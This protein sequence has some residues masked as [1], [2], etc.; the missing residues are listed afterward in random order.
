MTNIRA[1]A[2]LAVLLFGS[3][4]LP[5]FAQS[6]RAR[7]P[8]KP[9]D[10]QSDTVRLRVEEVLLP[11]SVRTETGKLPVRVDR[12]DFIVAEDGKRRVVNS[13]LRTPANVLFILDAGGDIAF[14]N[15]TLNRDLALKLIESLNPD[16][17]AAIITY[18]DRVNLIAGWTRDKKALR[19][20]L[21]WKFRPGLASELYASLLYAAD[22]V[23]SRVGG[24]RSVVILTDGVDSFDD[25][26]FEVALT[27]LHRARATVYVVSQSSILLARLKPEAF[28]AMVWLEM[29]DPRKR[30]SIERMRQYYRQLEAGAVTFKGLA[31]ETGGAA[32][33]PETVDEFKSLGDQITM[34]MRTEFVIAYQSRRPPEDSSFHAVRVAV[35]RTDLVVRSRR[36]VYSSAPTR[37]EAGGGARSRGFNFV[38]PDGG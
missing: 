38:N 27:G 15:P 18:G 7:A 26:S 36:G 23:L 30:V 5:A 12:S 6:G 2:L 28:N 33:Y 1:L 35:T 22:E 16:D 31:E 24:R 8:S 9:V 14:K 19:D 17:Q 3:A 20:A 37:P 11:V 4:A 10:S 29:L 32:W 13:V 25:R 34:E 21:Q